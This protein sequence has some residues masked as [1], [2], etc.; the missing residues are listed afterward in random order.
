M[1][2]R[3]SNS[4]DW[5]W[6]TLLAA[7]FALLTLCFDCS[8]A[9]AQQE[10]SITWQ[11]SAT[12][13]V[14]KL[15]QVPPAPPETG[16]PAPASETP[17]P[18]KAPPPQKSEESVKKAEPEE[19]TNQACMECHNAD[20]LKMSQRRAARPGCCRRRAASAQAQAPIHL[21]GNESGHTSQA[22]FGRHARGHDLCELPQGCR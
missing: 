20:I 2:Q 10:D 13:A 21:R 22:V 19:L 6:T 16:T 14:L 8:F 9:A 7:G 4:R 1:N 18:E 3:V 15:A 17:A 12:A 11:L 5:R